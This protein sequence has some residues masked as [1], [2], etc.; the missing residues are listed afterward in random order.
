MK[1]NITIKVGFFARKHSGLIISG[2]SIKNFH[3]GK[4]EKYSLTMNN[5]FSYTENCASCDARSKFALS[6]YLV[7]PIEISINQFL[8]CYI[9]RVGGMDEYVRLQ[10][11][12]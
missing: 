6:S 3:S 5:F 4:V 8:S 12:S 10:S 1:T 9:C 11:K 7:D 2:M